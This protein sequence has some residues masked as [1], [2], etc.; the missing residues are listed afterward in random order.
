MKQILITIAFIAICSL[1]QAQQTD[2]TQKIFTAVEQ[3]P[4]PAGGMAKF[5]EYLGTNTKYPDSAVK[6]RIEGKVFITFVVEN[7]GSLTNVKILRGVSPDI[8]AE[9]TRVVSTAPKW[10]PGMQNGRAV[11]VQYSMAISFKLPP[12][13][14]A[15]K[16]MDSM[17]NLPADQKIFSAV[18]QEP[19]PVGGMS[20][21]YQYLMTNIHYPEYEKKNNIQGKVFLTF[22]IEKDGTLNDIRVLR[23]VSRAIDA[24]AIR[25]L[26]NAPKWN[27]GMQSG[28]PVR[29]QYNVPLSFS[30]KTVND[31]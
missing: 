6:K 28:R 14:S 26:K 3:E 15:D 18:E 21:F 19:S 12:Q 22:V 1:A 11:R 10:T 29:V 24:E 16:K 8:D 31:N 20:A 13:T 25:V 30:L 5:Y 4:S 7:D 27:P 23:G 9:A 17:M 2:T